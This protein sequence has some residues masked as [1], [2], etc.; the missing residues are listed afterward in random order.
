M[1]G[2][3]ASLVSMGTSSHY[4]HNAGKNVGEPEHQTYLSN[5]TP[6]NQIVMN[7]VWT[8]GKPSWPKICIMYAKEE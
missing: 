5:I 1:E 8:Q 2:L 7:L 6:R 3:V 4:H